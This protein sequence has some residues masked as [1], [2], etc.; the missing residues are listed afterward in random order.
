[1]K[2][3]FASKGTGASISSLYHIDMKDAPV[4]DNMAVRKLLYAPRTTYDAKSRQWNLSGSDPYD[5]FKDI[6]DL[7][8][9]VY[10]VG[11]AIAERSKRP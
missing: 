1:M 7:Q 11:S 5:G 3:I 8:D 6:M 9:T 4:D 2:K 10:F